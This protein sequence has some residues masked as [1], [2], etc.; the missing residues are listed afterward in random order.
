MRIPFIGVPDVDYGCML[1]VR[2][3]CRE[4]Q[5]VS[6]LEPGVADW[7]R[8]MCCKYRK[9]VKC[10]TD[11]F[12]SC[13]ESRVTAH[14]ALNGFDDE[15]CADYPLVSADCLIPISSYSGLQYSIAATAIVAA[16]FCLS[17]FFCMR[18]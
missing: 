10:F 18:K 12:K 13:N 15:V 1:N 2:K 5:L 3:V 14:P 17:Y 8:D 7:T 9:L 4:H 11:T 16:V 6:E